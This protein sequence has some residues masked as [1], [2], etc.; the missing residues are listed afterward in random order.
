MSV[1]N[2]ERMRRALLVLGHNLVGDGFDGLKPI[3]VQFA[4]DLAKF[5]FAIANGEPWP[6]FDAT[7]R[8]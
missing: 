5:A 7:L 2:E 8:E 1:S 4:R 3:S 6:D